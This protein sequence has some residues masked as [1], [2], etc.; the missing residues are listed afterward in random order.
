MSSCSHPLRSLRRLLHS[1]QTAVDAPQMI[2][3]FVTRPRLTTVL[4]VFPVGLITPMMLLLLLIT[5]V[6]I[7][8]YECLWQKLTHCNRLD[9]LKSTINLA[10]GIGDTSCDG[11]RFCYGES[12]IWF[13]AN[14]MLLCVGPDAAGVL[15]VGQ[16]RRLGGGTQGR[17]DGVR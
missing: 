2:R 6:N 17:K 16:L 13:Y 14:T 10:V 7:V 1:D 12:R 4:F 8:C 11:V 5:T 3:H 9:Q 15:F